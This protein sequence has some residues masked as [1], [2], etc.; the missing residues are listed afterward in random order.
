MNPGLVVKLRPTG[1]WRIGSDSGAR[2]RVDSIYHSDSLYAAVASAMAR[3]GMLPEWL[4]ATARTAIPAVRFS[5]CFPFL[6][7]VSFIV[8]PRTVWPPAH[9]GASPRVRWK[10]ARFVP[11]SLLP[12]ILAGRK[13]DESKWGV[14][15]LSECLVPAGRSGPFR[16]SVRSN[17]AVDRLTGAAE[18]HSVACTEFRKGAGLWAIVAFADE[19]ARD[20][21]QEPVKAAFRWLADSGFGGERSRGW[22]RSEAPEFTEGELPEMVIGGRESGAGGQEQGAGG[23]GAEAQQPEPEL[24]PLQMEA[25]TELE[26]APTA[27]NELPTEPEPVPPVEEAE[28]ALPTQEPYAGSPETEPPAE[29]EQG[30]AS[31]L[32]PTEIAPLAVAAELQAEPP[33]PPSPAADAAAEETEAPPTPAEAEAN[34]EPDPV[35]A[36]PQEAGQPVTPA[37]PETSPEQ[38]L[39]AA[40]PVEPEPDPLP[41]LTLSPDSRP[42][43]AAGTPPGPRTLASES[44]PES[45]LVQK[46]WLLSLFTPAAT[47]AVDW[48]RG[49]YAV[50]TR[51]GRIESPAGG[52]ELKKQLTMVAEGSVLCSAEPPQGSAPDVAPEGFAHPVYRAGFAL[53]ISLPEVR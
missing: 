27:E 34:T 35:A 17:A 47:D 52:G 26:P 2:N 1:P 43:D 13:L 37:E 16:T 36:E 42:A 28:S 40:E 11:L 8:P 39:V 48:S 25:P 12:A 7:N 44:A 32:A 6:D 49:N 53:S 10:S 24:A 50:V 33:A 46:H 21:W 4:D 9:P 51:G 41:D 38:E 3:L 23:Q 30:A 15:A 18:R 45:S 20:R 14:D 22:G 5:S 31:V 19:S 29:P